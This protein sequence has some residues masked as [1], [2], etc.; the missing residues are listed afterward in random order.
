MNT[1]HWAFGM[2]LTCSHDSLT[3]SHNQVNVPISAISDILH[4]LGA[5]I[6][7]VSFFGMK[8]EISNVKL[9]I[10]RF[11]QWYRAKMGLYV[12]IKKNMFDYEVQFIDGL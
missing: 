5:K 6:C 4:S 1:L 3:L 10:D 2:T 9:M 8:W 7:Q 11:I 12:P